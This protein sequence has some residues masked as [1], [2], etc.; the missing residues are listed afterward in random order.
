M[1]KVAILGFG[2]VGSGVAEVLRRNGPHIDEKIHSAVELKYI[3][4][5][6]DFPNSP[7]APYV[8]HD[9]AQI[10]GDP[11]VDIV[12]ETIGGAKIAREFTEPRAP[13]RAR[14]WSPPTRNWWPSTAASCCA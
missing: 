14:A 9:F 11:E 13:V 4:D 3:L 5:V 12:V 7:F 8:V 1:A 2:V 6:R 10:E